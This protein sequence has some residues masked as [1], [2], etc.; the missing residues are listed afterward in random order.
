MENQSSQEAVAIGA[1]YQSNLF[2][3]SDGTI[4]YGEE[5]CQLNYGSCQSKVDKVE[6][7]ASRVERVI[8]TAM[9]E[10]EDLLSSSSSQE[11]QDDDPSSSSSAEEETSSPRYIYNYIP[12]REQLLHQKPLTQQ[13]SRRL[14]SVNSAVSRVFHVINKY[15][16]DSKSITSWDELLTSPNSPWKDYY[17]NDDNR[18]MMIDDALDEIVSA[19]NDMVHAWEDYF[20]SCDDGNEEDTEGKNKNMQSAKKKEEWWEPVLHSSKRRLNG[21]SDNIDDTIVTTTTNHQTNYDDNDQDYNNVQQQQQFHQVYMEY[22]TNAFST[23][24]EALRN[25]QLERI[26][27]S[28]KKKKKDGG[29]ANNNN[30]NEKGMEVD[31]DPT[32]HSF[33]VATNSAKHNDDDSNDAA[34][35]KAAAA[36]IDLQVLSEMLSSGLYTLNNLEKNMLLRA[37]QRGGGDDDD[38]S[39]SGRI[40]GKGGLSLHDQRRQELGL[41]P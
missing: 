19:R 36:D 20:N 10:E 6:L 24:L 8:M 3:S 7:G 35:A 16:G 23:E 41:L 27:A 13:Q 31:L 26:C 17:T 9:E 29:S 28:S 37:R 14:Q 39:G 2:P 4:H 34:R 1:I 15:G 12:S 33:V 18:G 38:N 40:G 32:Q 11:Q 21:G 22:A 25:G 30:N 5:L